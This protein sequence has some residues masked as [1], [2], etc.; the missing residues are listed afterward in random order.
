MLSPRAKMHNDL[1]MIV[2]EMPVKA[3]DPDAWAILLDENR[4]LAEELG[5]NIFIVRGG[6]LLTP[7]EHY[8]LPGLSRQMT[9]GLVYRLDIPCKEHD[10]GL[11]DAGTADDMFL[12]AAAY[13][14]RPD[15]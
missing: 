5:N 11:F 4:N 1:N 6:E 13:T 9:I 2:A 3:A 7:R 15:H 10:L 12:N 14:S 8:V